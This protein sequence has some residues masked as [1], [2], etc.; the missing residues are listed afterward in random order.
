VQANSNVPKLASPFP[1]GKQP[2]RGINIGGWLVLEV[3][4]YQEFIDIFSHILRLHSSLSTPSH[5]E[6]L[7]NT[8]FRL[9][10]AR[11]TLLQHSRNITQRFTQSSH[12]KRYEMPGLTTLEF[13]FHTGLF[14]TSILMTRTWKRLA[15]GIFCEV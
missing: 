15:G 7:M 5:S 11:K 10:W 2:I 3:R 14:K 6:L 4:T 12:L 13:R 8:H 1:Y 9:T